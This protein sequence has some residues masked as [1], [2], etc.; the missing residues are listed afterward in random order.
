MAKFEVREVLWLVGRRELV[1]A[2]TVAEGK[3]AA[4]MQA[5][6][7]LDSQAFWALPIKSVEFIDRVSV[8]ESLVGLVI[9]GLT[10]EDAAVCS[11]LCPP[12]DAI[13][14]SEAA[15]AL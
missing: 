3:I 6:V 4:G 2:G 9:D 10:E 5:L 14:V 8:G 15:S 7:W 1:L 13:E 12:G 11:E